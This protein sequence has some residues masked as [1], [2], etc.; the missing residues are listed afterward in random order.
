MVDNQNHRNLGCSVAFQAAKD[1]A[2]TYDPNKCR[3]FDEYMR[4]ILR[5]DILRD[6]RSE[7]MNFITDGKSSMLADALKRD[8]KAVVKRIYSMEENEK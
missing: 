6:L 5:R 7:W 8:Y 1:Y 2:D 3:G 4:K